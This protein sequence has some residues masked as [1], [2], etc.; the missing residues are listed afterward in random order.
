MFASLDIIQHLHVIVSDKQ[1]D[2]EQVAFSVCYFSFM[3]VAKQNH[4]LFSA[5]LLF[6]FNARWQA[7]ESFPV[8]SRLFQQPQNER[9]VLKSE[10]SALQRAGWPSLSSSYS[11]SLPDTLLRVMAYDRFQAYMVYAMLCYKSTFIEDLS[12]FKLIKKVQTQ[13]NK[14]AR[15]SIYSMVKDSDMF[16]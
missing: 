7:W 13:W 4:E 2:V 9:F 15:D 3:A 8:V 1:Y 14:G 11:L 10:V 6:A 16:V 5:E 12:S